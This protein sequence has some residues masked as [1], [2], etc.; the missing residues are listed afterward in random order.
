MRRAAADAVRTPPDLALIAHVPAATLRRAIPVALE[1]L[2]PFSEP[3]PSEGATIEL[4]SGR[5]VIIVY[6]LETERLCVHA[7]KPDGPSAVAD[8]LRESK[9]GEASIEWL[10]PRFS[11]AIAEQHRALAPRE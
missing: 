9:I 2:D 10:D 6:G 5:H 7:A 8:F 11:A 3:E 4:A 1:A